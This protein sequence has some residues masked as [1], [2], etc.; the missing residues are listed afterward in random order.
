MPVVIYQGAKY[1]GIAMDV[2]EGSGNKADFDIP[3]L[4]IW[5]G[6]GTGN[7]DVAGTSTKLANPFQT[8]SQLN[9]NSATSGLTLI[10][11][12]NITPQIGTGSAPYLTDPSRMVGLNSQS[13]SSGVDIAILIPI[14]VLNGISTNSKI[15]V[16]VQTG[17]LDDAGPEQIGFIDPTNLTAGGWLATSTTVTTTFF[18]ANTTI[19]ASGSPLTFS[20]TTSQTYSNSGAVTATQVLVGALTFSKGEGTVAVQ[21]VAAQ[22]SALTFDSL[23]RSG[24]GTGNFTTPDPVNNQITFSAPPPSTNSILSAALFLNGANYAAYDSTG[25]VRALNYA[26]DTNTATSAGGATLG[27]VSGKDVLMNGA[28]TAQ[29]SLAVNSLKI[30]GDFALTLGNNQ[31]LTTNG[32]LKTGGTGTTISAGSGAAIQA[33]AGQDLVIRVDTATDNLT[34]NTSITA[35]GTNRL[36]KS[37]A[38]NLT[39][40]G[41][42]SYTGDTAVNAGTLT[43]NSSLSG[44]SVIEVENTGTL[45]G[46]GSIGTTT[47]QTNLRAGGRISP[48][49]TGGAGV[50]TLTLNGALTTSATSAIQLQLSADGYNASA[51]NAN[52]TLKTS[53]LSTSANRVAG[54]ND[55]LNITGSLNLS[56]GTSVYVSLI[57]GYTPKAGDAFDLLDWGSSLNLN[58]FTYG[59]GLRTG[60]AADNLNYD[61]KLPDLTASNL[62]WDV[63][64][65]ATLG[66]IVAVP[67]PGR[68]LLTGFGMVAVF[69]R[70]SRPARR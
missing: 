28:V 46:T 51:M 17:S 47:A 59:T 21:N 38:G 15:Y 26:T 1:F 70:R 40:N 56:S 50:G 10:Y 61:L 27:A 33:N 58:G 66:V 4:M 69:L 48:G 63:S 18:K 11:K 6:S 41:A 7:T 35:N 14:S 45:A 57:N 68:A 44:T 64:Q 8:F 22:N 12:Q 62:Y 16:G 24:S 32:I 3:Q 25:Y 37:G 19:Q 42:G 29:I 34:V 13:G 39:L 67:E 55:N 2:N 52:G 54:A 36:I 23:T 9:D 60:S 20:T 49:V 53:L 65:F 31:V 30:S 5:A 43:V